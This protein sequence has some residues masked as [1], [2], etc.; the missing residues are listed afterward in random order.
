MGATKG[1]GVERWIPA[2]FVTASA[3]GAIILGAVTY[4]LSTNISL[5]VIAGLAAGVSYI[6]ASLT[7]LEVYYDV[8]AAKENRTPESR[9]LTTKKW[10]AR[11]VL[12]ANV[13]AFALATYKLI[14]P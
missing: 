1:N 4:R 8:K 9:A 6:V 7:A 12:Y 14:V 11:I 3:I 10:R 5:A 2:T 13:A